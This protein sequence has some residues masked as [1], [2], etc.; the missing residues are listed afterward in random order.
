MDR[1]RPRG[2]DHTRGGDH[3]GD[4]VTTVFMDLVQ[5]HDPGLRML[6]YRLLQDRMEMDDAM[7]DAYLKAFRSLPQFRGEAQTRTWLYRIV[8]NTCLDRL[9]SRRRRREVGLGALADGAGGRDGDLCGEGCAAAYAA[10]RVLPDSSSHPDPA[11]WVARHSDLAGALAS[12]PEDQRATVLL[13]D[14]AGLT[15]E[16][17]AE[18]LGVRPGTIGSRLSHARS[19]LQ[20]V[21][22]GA[23]G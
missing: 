3:A 8:Y 18:V 13:V 16:E 21:L 9:R 19:V 1:N 6:A 4:R 23:E 5:R 7:Q 14:A 10:R 11:E 2:G 12:L 15:Y 22:A 20:T 17:A